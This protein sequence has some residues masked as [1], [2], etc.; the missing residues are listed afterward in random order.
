MKKKVQP[1]SDDAKGKTNITVLILAWLVFE[2]NL[3]GGVFMRKLE[4]FRDGM[5]T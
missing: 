4:L 3:L 2:E 1:Q 5:T